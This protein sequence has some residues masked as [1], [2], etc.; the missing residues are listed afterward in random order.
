M[1][2]VYSLSKARRREKSPRMA[3]PESLLITASMFG[4][5]LPD[6]FDR[7]FL[8]RTKQGTE[9]SIKGG[10]LTINLSYY[11]KVYPENFKA[12]RQWIF[13][14]A[15]RHGWHMHETKGRL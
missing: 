6:T 2:Q 1:S 5:P 9:V 7:F 12:A 13:A 15:D 3:M 10:P 14:V 4:F 11:S 8:R